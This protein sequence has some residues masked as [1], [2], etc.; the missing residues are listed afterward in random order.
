MKVHLFWVFLA[1]ISEKMSE[2][3]VYSLSVNR[4]TGE[5]QVQ[6]ENRRESNGVH[7]VTFETNF[8]FTSYQDNTSVNYLIQTDPGVQKNYWSA[9]T[10]EVLD[11]RSDPIVFVGICCDLCGEGWHLFL[12]RINS[13][14]SCGRFGLYCRQLHR[15]L[16]H[17]V[18]NGHN[19][20]DYS[21]THW[22]PR[23][24]WFN[25]SQD[26]HKSGE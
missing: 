16:E 10:V 7:Q 5:L 25:W 11:F 9:E 19:Q 3:A 6:P 1:H 22:N 4:K 12:R 18:Y 23:E 8:C 26:W 13:S 21:Q 17:Q 2:N 14:N 24:K 15:P 20:K